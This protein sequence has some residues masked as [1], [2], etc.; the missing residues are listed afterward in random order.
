MSNSRI[1]PEFELQAP[2]SLTEAVDLAGGTDVIIM[3]EKSA[4]KPQYVI[5]L[6]KISG[7][8]YIQ[9]SKAEGLRI[10]A[11]ATAWQVVQNAGV[12]KHY[13]ALCINR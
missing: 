8:D 9:Y 3:L 2:Q 13:P 5:A 1:L 6:G 11:L 4:I 7:P 12:K 10:G